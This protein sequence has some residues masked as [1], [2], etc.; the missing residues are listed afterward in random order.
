MMPVQPDPYPQDHNPALNVWSS[1]YT[2]GD[3]VTIVVAFLDN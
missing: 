3:F 1:E 2:Q